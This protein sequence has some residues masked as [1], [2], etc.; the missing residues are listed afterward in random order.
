[1]KKAKLLS[2]EKLTARTTAS[3]ASSILSAPLFT[4]SSSSV[5]FRVS[6]SSLDD[7]VD[8]LDAFYRKGLLFKPLLPENEKRHGKEEKQ[9]E[10]IQQKE[11]RTTGGQKEDLLHAK[12]E[13]ERLKEKK[14]KLVLRLANAY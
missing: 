9:V 5:S 13:E 11:K 8:I 7:L 1:M 10:G 14:K 2:I 3:P 6:Y 12:G 4:S